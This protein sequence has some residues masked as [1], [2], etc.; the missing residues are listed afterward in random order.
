MKKEEAFKLMQLHDKGYVIVVNDH[1]Y[2]DTPVE[3]IMQSED[4]KDIFY[5]SQVFSE[6]SLIRVSTHSVQVLKPVE[7]WQSIDV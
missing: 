5:D 2:V 6:R 1:P 3:S 7:N 4:E